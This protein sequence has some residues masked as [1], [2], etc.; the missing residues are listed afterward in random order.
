MIP[1]MRHRLNYKLQSFMLPG[2]KRWIGTICIG[3]AFVVFGVLLIEGVHPVDE[4]LKLIKEVLF[5]ASS[6][7]PY[8]KS[9]LMVILCGVALCAV[10]VYR[11]VRSVLGAYMSE[12]RESIPD[13]LYKRRHLERGPRVVVIGGGTGLGTLLRGLKHHTSNITAIV[14][15]GDDGGSSGRLRYALGMVPPGDLRN[16]ITALADEDKLVTELFN[17]R[18][19][20]AGEELR[21][22]NFGNLFLTAVYSMTHGDMIEA[23]GLASRLLNSRGT[24]LPASPSAIQLVAEMADGE[25][26]K[27]E[28]HITA[29]RGKIKKL[30]Y[31]PSGIKPSPHTIEAILQAEMIVLGPGSLY[32]SVIPNLLIPGIADAIKKSPARKVYVTNVLTQLGETTGYTVADHI[33]AILDHAEVKNEEVG[34]FLE[35]VLVNDKPPVI[36]E[37]STATAVPF[38]AERVKSLGITAVQRP[39]VENNTFGHHDSIKLAEALM[40]WLLEEKRQEKAKAKSKMAVRERFASFF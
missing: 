37:D 8:K 22:H 28:S 33:E 4:T 18:F 2:L 15:V 30:S 40:D 1:D 11:L 19:D 12:E 6:I 29:A 39:L 36:P 38:D 32:T 24:V 31:E 21:G 26:V 10:A 3:I 9:G 20:A 14:T 27:G 17:Y 34:S 25:I 23:A 13:V 7:V 5:H 16:C 35:V